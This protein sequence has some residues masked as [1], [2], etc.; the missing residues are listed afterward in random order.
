MQKKA[1]VHFQ[2]QAEHQ[3]NVIIHLNKG[4]KDALLITT[5]WQWWQRLYYGKQNIVAS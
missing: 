4:E 2:T 3:I 1:N 5:T